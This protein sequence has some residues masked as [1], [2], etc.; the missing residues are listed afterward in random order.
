MDLS[1]CPGDSSFGPVI[2]GCR[3][4]FD[5]TLQFEKIFFSIIPLCIFI[6][7]SL[8]RCIQ[9]TRG[10]V[11]A[12]GP[13]LRYTKMVSLFHNHISIHVLSQTAKVLYQSVA[14]DK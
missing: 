10:P 4:S 13:V 8:A 5:F 6:A 2:L 7:A 9:L 3:G 14:W 1:G 12:R 11:V